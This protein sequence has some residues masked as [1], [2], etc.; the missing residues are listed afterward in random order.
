M[1]NHFQRRFVRERG[2]QL[3]DSKLIDE[4]YYVVPDLRSRD[5]PFRVFGAFKTHILES[6]KHKHLQAV[7]KKAVKVLLPMIHPNKPSDI[8]SHVRALG[9]GFIDSIVIAKEMKSGYLLDQFLW[10]AFYYQADVDDV[11]LQ[12]HNWHVDKKLQA[13]F[14]AGKTGFPII[15]ASINQLIHTG[16][17]PNKLRM[18]VASF[19]CKNMLQPW[20][21]GEV[22][23][24]KYLEDYDRV[25]NR[26]N[27]IW[28]SQLRYDNQQFIRFFKPEN[29]LKAWLKTE[30]GSEWYDTWKTKECPEI[31]DWD[32]SC[33]RYRKWIIKAR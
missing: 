6:I 29:Q 28:C 20:M 14:F 21:H 30:G 2:F 25:L 1:T 8:S 5:R 19:F 11:E 27:W 22:F 26:G 9:L 10:R 32:K 23:F 31:I 13:K 12:Q 33:D 4:L 15:D 3:T 24:S 7:N 16:K 17:L 18:V